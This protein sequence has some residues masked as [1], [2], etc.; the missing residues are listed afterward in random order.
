MSSTPIPHVELLR[1]VGFAAEKHR[2]QRRKD[3]EKSPYINHPIAVA[4]ALAAVG[5]VL[6]L[7]TLQAAVLHDTIEDTETTPAE[8]EEAFG[9]EVRDL[10]VEVTDDKALPKAE[11][12][13]LQIEHAAHLSARAR[14]IKTADK[15]CNV[16]DVTHEPP[17][18]WS[19]QQRIEYLEWAARVVEGCRGANENLERYFDEVLERGRELLSSGASD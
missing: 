15:I 1:A 5:G 4:E 10:V 18:E 12:K 11:R 7:A 13:R 2:H 8:L 17:E 6:D 3:G 14:M 19:R 16:R 9:P